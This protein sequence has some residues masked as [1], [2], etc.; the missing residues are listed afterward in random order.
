MPYSGCKHNPVCSSYALCLLLLALLLAGCQGNDISEEQPITTETTDEEQPITT[1]TTGEEQPVTMLYVPTQYTTI[2]KAIDSA[3]SG[4]IIIIESGIYNENLVISDKNVTIASRYYI[5]N[6]PADIDR[7]IIDG[8]RKAVITIQGAS[9][10]SSVIGLTISNGEDGILTT[11]KV[12]ILSNIIR[13][14]NDGI[15]Y[16]GGGGVCKNNLITE[17]FDDAIDLDGPV[18]VIIE[19][20]TL[21]NNRDDGIEIRFHLFSGTTLVTEILNNKITGNGEDGIQFIGYNATTDRKFTIKRNLLANNAM[22]AI[23][24][25]DETIS[26]EDYRGASLD[27]EIV[28]VNNTISNNKYG[29]TGGANTLVVNNIFESTTYTA[30]KNVISDS[31]IYNNLFWD[32][33]LNFDNTNGDVNMLAVDPKLNVDYTLTAD[34]PAIDSGVNTVNWKADNITITEAYSGTA[35]DPGFAEYE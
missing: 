27:E 2:Q 22:A 24:M 20:N 3:N 1:E 31:L 34:S 10:G 9:A 18:E 8:N 25:M 15:D 16:E 12:N 28:I 5:T 33:D 30:L 17:N 14:N 4:D 35:P 21:L 32:N 26:I 19:D 11:A 13:D 29:I 7:T 23:G 6:D